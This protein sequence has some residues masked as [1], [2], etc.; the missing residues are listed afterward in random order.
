MRSLVI[1]SKD[2]K[3]FQQSLGNPWRFFS[4]WNR[5]RDRTVFSPASRK[6]SLGFGDVEIEGPRRSLSGP[7]NT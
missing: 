6:V 4:K 5:L 2:C 7:G 3:Y 1:R